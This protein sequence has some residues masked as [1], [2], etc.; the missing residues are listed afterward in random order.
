MR[1]RHLVPLVVLC[2]TVALAGWSASH[3]NLPEPAVAPAAISAD[4]ATTADPDP[5]ETIFVLAGF[6]A[7]ETPILEDSLQDSCPTPPP[8][9]RV[10]LASLSILKEVKEYPKPVVRPVETPNECLVAEICID[11]YLWSFYERTPKVDTNKV[12]ER[13]KTTVKKKGKT[14]TVIKTIT[15]YVVGRLHMEGSDSGAKSRH[16]AQ[17]LRDRRHGSWLQAEALPRASRDGR[18]RASCRA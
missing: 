4:E 2:G 14:R 17:G 16:V 1:S 3:L 6:S 15:K 10:Q 13:I 12:T 11:D 7:A 5:S 9:T 18:R 8:E